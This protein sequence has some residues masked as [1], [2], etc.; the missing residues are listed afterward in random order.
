MPLPVLGAV[1]WT[2]PLTEGLVSSPP[3]AD[4]GGQTGVTRAGAPWERLLKLFWE[5]APILATPP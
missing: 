2:V 1:G 4:L 3:C 5:V